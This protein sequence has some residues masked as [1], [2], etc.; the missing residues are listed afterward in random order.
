MLELAG[1]AVHRV[2][3]KKAMAGLIYTIREQTEKQ[4]IKK[5]QESRRRLRGSRRKQTGCG[6][7][8]ISTSK[9]AK[10]DNLIEDPN[11]K[12]RGLKRRQFKQTGGTEKRRNMVTRMEI[13]CQN[14]N[15]CAENDSE[16]DNR[17]QT[18]DESLSMQA[19]VEGLPK[20]VENETEMLSQ[21]HD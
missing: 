11:I 2:E 7:G 21:N 18:G 17:M 15:D 19:G 3:G 14:E 1:R 5:R 6:T 20:V 16:E 9:I 4:E 10:I 8:S 12:V 13:P